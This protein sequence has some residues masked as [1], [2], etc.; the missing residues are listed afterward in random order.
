LDKALAMQLEAIEAIL[1]KAQA[2]RGDDDVGGAQR[3]LNEAGR[4]AREAVHQHGGEI[5]V[6]KLEGLRTWKAHRK[7]WWLSGAT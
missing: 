3:L 1:A 2:K 4:I 5:T 6:P 7:G